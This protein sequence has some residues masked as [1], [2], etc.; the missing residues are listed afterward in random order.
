MVDITDSAKDYLVDLLSGQE[1]KDVG[2]RIFITDP[3]TPMAETC[4]AYCRAG[5]EQATDQRVDY[6]RFTAWIDDR[7]QPF[8]ED[9]VVDY[10]SDK[11]GGQL[12]IKAPNARVPKVSDDSPIE[13]R[14]NY[15]LHAEINPSLAAHGGMISLVE[16][17][18]GNIA[19]LQF[20]GGC[21]GCGMVDMTLKEGVE[22]TLL[23]HLPELKGIRDVTDHSI[24]EN[25][26]M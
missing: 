5:E 17:V 22:K 21:Q 8:L 14:I 24:R 11:M 18:D 15:V 16:V 13:D 19:I 23:Q 12:T 25:A 3:G 2:V 26:Y 1:D 6:G 4:L 10:A 9:A 7:S 20:G